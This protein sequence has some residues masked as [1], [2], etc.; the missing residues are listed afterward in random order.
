MCKAGEIRLARLTHDSA[1]RHTDT[2]AVP[3]ACFCGPEKAVLLLK[4]EWENDS[5]SGEPGLMSWT[6]MTVV[7]ILDLSLDDKADLVAFRMT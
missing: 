7:S 4:Q 2:R 5:G 3:N 6:S 1:P